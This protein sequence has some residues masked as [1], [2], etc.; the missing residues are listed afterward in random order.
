MIAYCEKVDTCQYDSWLGI[1]Y[2]FRIN[3]DCFAYL[4]R[5]LPQKGNYNFYCWCYERSALDAVLNQHEN[6]N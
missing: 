5:C 2:I 4:L 1:Q 6:N 3:T